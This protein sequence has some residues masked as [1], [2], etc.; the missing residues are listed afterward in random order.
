MDN[1]TLKNTAADAL[2][3][4]QYDP[5]RLSLLHSA[6]AVALSLVATLVNFLLTRGI[7]TTAG[8][9][10]IGTRTT[11]SM[12]QILLSMA[13]SV[14]LPFWE[15]GLVRAGICLSRR[16]TADPG[17]LP[18]GFRRFG[19]ALRLMLLKSL[20]CMAVA[21]LCLQLSTMLYL[22]SSLSNDFLAAAKPLI[23]AETV[24]T[25][26]MESLLPYIYPLYLLFGGLTCLVLIPLLYRFRLADMAVMDDAPG[27]RA[28]LRISASAM[29]LRRFW[30]F[31]LDLSFWWYYALSLLATAV[32]YG[33]LALKA[34]Q[35][36]INE[37]VAFWIFYA[38]GAAI[39]LVI[40][41]RFAPLVQTTYATAYDALRTAPQPLPP[42]QS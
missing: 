1:R 7:D 16:R 36:P 38:L 2:S 17:V 12:V 10:G 19:P 15:L 41:W 21:V 39:Q 14:A 26:A 24:D 34:L 4:A 35:V 29:K 11:L 8:L 6:A 27:A 33:D 32:T 23:E 9:A 25:A 18:E 42:P 5:H 20:L 22:F 31:K 13:I 37:D 3:A 30:F 28:A 40:G